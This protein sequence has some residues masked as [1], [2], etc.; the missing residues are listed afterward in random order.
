MAQSLGLPRINPRCGHAVGRQALF[1]DALN[2]GIELQIGGK[3]SLMKLFYLALRNISQ[4]WTLPIRDWKEA[5]TRFTIQ[6][7]KWRSFSIIVS[8][9]VYWLI[10]RNKQGEH[11]NP[12]TSISLGWH[13]DTV[14]LR[15]LEF[16]WLDTLDVADYKA[17]GYFCSG[18]LHAKNDGHILAAARPA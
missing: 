4:K 1:Q 10:W 14:Q 12:P 13:Q 7:E 15:N 2:D 11:P 9:F 8:L 18:K 3:L 16:E 6:F 17:V 5:L